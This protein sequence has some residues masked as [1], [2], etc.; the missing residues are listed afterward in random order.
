[1]TAKVCNRPVYTVVGVSLNGERDILGL[2]VGDGSEGAK[3][4]HQVLTE[5]LNRGTVD[6]CIV[7][8]D[9]LR[10][11]P[12]AIADVWPQAIAQTCVLHLIRNT[13]RYASKADWAELARDLRPLHSAPTEQATRERLD[14]PA[15]KWGDR[16]P[17][18]IKLWQNARAEFMPFL[19]YSPEIREALTPLI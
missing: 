3:Y 6:V 4:W 7:C 2:W 10:G 9:G 17:A 11:L 16:Y 5:I 1:V 13:F 18:I 19:A 8:C 12:E 14:E 15:G